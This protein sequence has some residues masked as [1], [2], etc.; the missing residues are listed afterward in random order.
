M[1]HS[2]A[3]RVALVLAPISI[4]HTYFKDFIDFTVMEVGMGKDSIK[5]SSYGLEVLQ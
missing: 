2:I 1:C 3:A 5:S 4:L